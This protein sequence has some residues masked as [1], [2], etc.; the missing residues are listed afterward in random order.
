[1]LEVK[2]P[3]CHGELIQLTSD[4]EFDIATYKCENCGDYY[5]DVDIMEIAHGQYWTWQYWYHLAHVYDKADF[6]NSE[7]RSNFRK[8]FEKLSVI[9][10]TKNFE[11][12]EDFSK[13]LSEMWC[14]P[15]DKPEDIED[16][17]KQARGYLEY[18][19]DRM[20]INRWLYIRLL[21]NLD[22]K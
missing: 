2:C 12:Y 20:Y 6:S 11:K 16:A 17:Y 19:S 4:D 8:E 14:G 22:V 18:A 9:W 5:D 13:D 7:V 10:F 3:I 15:I 21:L 1:M